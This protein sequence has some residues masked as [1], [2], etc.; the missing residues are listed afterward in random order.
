MISKV[1]A[2]SP[3]AGEPM[4]GCDPLTSAFA[5]RQPALFLRPE[6]EMTFGSAAADMRAFLDMGQQTF[7]AS[8]GAHGSSM[9]V[10]SRVEGDTEETWN[11]VLEFLKSR[12]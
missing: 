12:D 4:L 9:L 2:F 11:T 10:N 6:S 8:P 1:L 5:L 7:I 3:A